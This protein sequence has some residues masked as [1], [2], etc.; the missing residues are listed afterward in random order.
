MLVRRGGEE[1]RRVRGQV[2]DRLNGRRRG[3]LQ[4]PDGRRRSR[5]K[6]R[7]EG[8]KEVRP[9]METPAEEVK[10]SLSE[11][12]RVFFSVRWKSKRGT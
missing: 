7:T 2:V 1:R 10:E 5:L 8:G 4:G 6:D 11:A 12:E 9:E 3:H